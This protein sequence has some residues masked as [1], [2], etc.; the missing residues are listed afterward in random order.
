MYWLARTRGYK[1]GFIYFR[2]ADDIPITS[3]KFNCFGNWE[4][5]KTIIEEVSNKYCISSDGIKKTRLY[6]FSCSMGANHLGLYLV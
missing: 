2:T 6:V 4:D 3:H 5:C 1:V